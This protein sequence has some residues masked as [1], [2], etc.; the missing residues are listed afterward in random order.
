MSTKPVQAL[1]KPLPQ[2][3]DAERSV[4]G[5]ILLD[6]ATLNALLQETP[7]LNSGDFFHDHHQRL[8][9]AMVTMKEHDHPIDLV[10]LV[11]HLH[12]SNQ[13]TSAGGHAYIA[14]L[15]DGVPHV[16]NTAHYARIIKEKARLRGII[17]LTHAI[18]QSALDPQADLAD[19]Q[20]RMAQFVVSSANTLT[21]TNGNGHIGHDLMDFLNI[22]FPQPEHLIEGII[23]R[24]DKVMIVAM[25]HR[26]K[27]FLTMG[28]ALA[29]TRPG[30]ALGK[31]EVKKPVR[32][33]LMQVEDAP[34][35]VQKRL[36]S[37][38]ESPQ[39]MGI[40]EKNV[41]IIDR[42]E[43]TRFDADWCERI[44][45]QAIE[46][47]ADMLVLDVLRKF[48]IGH[49]DIN[50]S[51]DTA[52]FLEILDKI[53]YMTGAT[54]VVV[55][56][57]NRKEAELMYASAG[58]YNL[59][60]WA[61]SVIQIKRKTEEKNVTRVEIEVDNKFANPLEPMRMVLD[62]SSSNPLILEALEE[63]TGFRD[64]M[65][66]L[67]SEWTVRDLMEVLQATRSGA[68]RR[69][70]KWL[71]MDQVE[72]VTGGKK[73]PHGGLAKYREVSRLP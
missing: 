61:T 73:G 12:S 41:R 27:S 58:S 4:L 52:I 49:G 48:F 39:F 3:I 22:D 69:L 53:R 5:A 47:K 35:E 68:N 63:G 42:T 37:F 23:P 6:N 16:T 66:Q 56:H 20:H 64:A 30:T 26:L 62:F 24:A 34:G 45:R 36:R 55:H 29:A 38:L 31:L 8:F 28:L 46:W 19:V 1:E 18:Q 50:S 2:N 65:A 9:H 59:P 14:S 70:K 51:T 33:M 10:T 40:D 43:F 72:K 25:P 71:E 11:E 57:E 44:V 21:T 15:M 67:G 60:G 13:L 54:I 32:T 7:A 17:H